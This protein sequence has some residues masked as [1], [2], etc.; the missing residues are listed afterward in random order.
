[1]CQFLINNL[2]PGLF[3][4]TLALILQ[5]KPQYFTSNGEKTSVQDELVAQNIFLFL[6]LHLK[7]LTLFC[8]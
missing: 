3:W 2:S 8:T 6:R 1:M 4:L 7:I 5:A